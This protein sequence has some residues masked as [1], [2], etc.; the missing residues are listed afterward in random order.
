MKHFKF[1][2]AL[3]TMVAPFVQGGTSI[4]IPGPARSGINIEITEQLANENDVNAQKA[5]GEVYLNQGNYTAA[6]DWFTKGARQ[7]DAACEY[8][9]GTMYEEGRGVPTDMES[10]IRWYQ[11]A[12][13][14]GSAEAAYVLGNIYYQ[15]RGGVPQ[16]LKLASKWLAVAAE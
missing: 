16:D 8:W 11:R 14:H 3:L 12:A 13:K 6:F 2:A 4:P 10:A 15:G 5:L 7:K 9:L 1:F